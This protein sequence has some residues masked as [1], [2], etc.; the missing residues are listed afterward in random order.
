[1]KATGP[2]PYEL[3]NSAISG[4]L[5]HS[6]T[7]SLLNQPHPCPGALHS[8]QPH[9]IPLPAS[10]VRSRKEN[11]H[12]TN[13]SYSHSPSSN[14][15]PSLEA[16]IRRF[17]Q[18]SNALGV[19]GNRADSSSSGPSFSRRTSAGEF[20]TEI[21]NQATPNHTYAGVA[22]SGNLPG[23]G[24]EK[25]A[26]RNRNFTP[27]SAK[28]IDEEDE[29]RRVSPRMRIATS[30]SKDVKGQSQAASEQPKLA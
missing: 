13:S 26:K 11:R 9:Q 30:V 29:P 3:P 4:E 27:A 12:L 7:Q 8:A 21:T 2:F 18:T 14:A 20:G 28:A 15:S 23:S 1:M 25:G 24:S 16:Q 19:T 6:L 10:E 17:S 22:A 5:A